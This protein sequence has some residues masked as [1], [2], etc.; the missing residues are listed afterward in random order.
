MKPRHYVITSVIT[1]IFFLIITLPATT[2]T[3]L[4]D[5]SVPQINIQGVDGTLWNGSARRISISSKY[6]VDN[7]NWSFC[8]W[9]LLTAEAC[10]N[11]DA[12][13]Q[14]RPIQ[15][16][17]GIGI[18]GALIARNLHTEIDAQSLGNLAGLPIG[19]LDG[20]ISIQLESA[21]WAREQTPDA[22]GNIHWKNAAVTIA[23][24]TKLGDV[25]ITLVESDDFPLVATINNKGGQISL[26]G[27]SHISDDG[28]YDLEL[29]L[30]PNNTTS[31]NLRSS[32]EMFAEQQNDGSFVVKNTGNLEQF[33]IL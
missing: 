5:E 3:S 23:E 14:N 28:S 29:K 17:L 10:I 21:S 25:E 4:L 18:T 19:E 11:I 15:G 12:T 22:V 33:G 32:L 9:R 26:D 6:V 8:S 30:S 16:Q 13:Y 2:V 7:V 27:K 20:L 24:T 1:Y 31:K